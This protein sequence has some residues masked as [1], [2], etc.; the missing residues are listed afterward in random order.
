MRKNTLDNLLETTPALWKGRRPNHRQHTLPTGYARLDARLPGGGW[1]LGAVTE[2]VSWQPGLGEFS[3]LLPVLAELGRQAQWTVLVDPPNI[4]Y[5]ASLHARGLSLERL[6]V[7]RS[8]SD[9][10]SLWACEQALR[11]GRGGAV[12]AWPERIGFTRLRRLQLAAQE[13][14]KLAFLYR[15]AN[16]VGEPSPAALR[17]CLEPADRRGTRISVLK[18]RGSHP[19]GPVCIRFSDYANSSAQ[20]WPHE[21]FAADQPRTLLAGHPPAAP[22]AGSAHPRGEMQGNRGGRQRDGG[23]ARTDH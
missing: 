19:P 7:V 15:P 2:L 21:P 18:C 8:R 16:A 23:S 10:E 13:N 1:P 6:L 12:L 4:P 9:K 17:L 5:P 11:S 22:R 20:T 14:A 3:L